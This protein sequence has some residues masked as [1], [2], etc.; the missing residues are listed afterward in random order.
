MDCIIFTVQAVRG[1]Q[2]IRD[3]VA[4]CERQPSLGSSRLQLGVAPNAKI[5]LKN[6]KICLCFNTTVVR[7]FARVSRS[8][9]EVTSCSAVS[10]IST[11][12]C[13]ESLLSLEIFTSNTKTPTYVCRRVVYVYSFIHFIHFDGKEKIKH[14]FKGPVWFQSSLWT[15]T[16]T[17]PTFIP[18]VGCCLFI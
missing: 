4:P 10:V 3:Q 6:T 18:F 16:N 2:N 9:T 11:R 15:M 14:R 12:V 8:T 13:V 17:Q 1:I 7:T 5:V